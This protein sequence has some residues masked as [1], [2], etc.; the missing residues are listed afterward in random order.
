M[1]LIP[2]EVRLVDGRGSGTGP[3]QR[4]EQEGQEGL[5]RDA[6]DRATWPWGRT[7]VSSLRLPGSWIWGCAEERLER[8]PWEPGE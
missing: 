2:R 5:G 6:A 7:D 4:A 8:V 1:L 3:L